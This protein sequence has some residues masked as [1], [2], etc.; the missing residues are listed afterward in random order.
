MNVVDL[1]IV[2]QIPIEL[3]IAGFYCHSILFPSYNPQPWS[4]VVVARLKEA[5]KLVVEA[6]LYAELFSVPKVMLQK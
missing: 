3:E 2:Y 5:A 1:S 4:T 6:L